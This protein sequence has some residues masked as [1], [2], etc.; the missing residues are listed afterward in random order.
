MRPI[1][2]ALAIRSDAP[3]EGDDL[4]VST[5]GKLLSPAGWRGNGRL[6]TPSNCLEFLRSARFRGWHAA[7]KLPMDFSFWD[8][9]E[10]RKRG[11]DEWPLETSD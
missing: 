2:S 9:A 8:D 1:F 10:A 6:K 4:D 5:G 3:Q 11:N 7:E